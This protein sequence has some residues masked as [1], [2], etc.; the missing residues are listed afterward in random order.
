MPTDQPRPEGQEIPLGAGG[1]QHVRGVDAHAR[2]HHRQLV[3]QCNVQI[4]LGVLDHLGSF[5]HFD[6]RGF[7][8][9]GR[10]HAGVNLG[11][12]VQRCRITAG[13]H[14][15]DR[16]E[17]MFFVAG[18]DALGAVAA[19]EIHAVLEAGNALQHRHAIF[20]G[21]AGVDGGFID[22]DVPLL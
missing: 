7:V 13:H 5:G 3:H 17:A 18:V 22:D 12:H 14:F 6:G 16:L 19:E 9:T 8:D 10:H 11:H 15:F 4:A 21:R 1:G 2:E 20:L